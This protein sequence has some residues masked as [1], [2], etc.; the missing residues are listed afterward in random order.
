MNQGKLKQ[1][2]P[3]LSEEDLNLMARCTPTEKL[4]PPEEIPEF[5]WIPEGQFIMGDIFHN[6][7]N[8]GEGQNDERPLRNLNLHGF[9]IAEN[10]VTNHEYLKFLENADPDQTAD[11]LEEIKGVPEDAPVHS[12]TWDDADAYCKWREAQTPG[13]CVSLPTEAQWEKASSWHLI[14]ADFEVGRKYEFATGTDVNYEHTAFNRVTTF[15]REISKLSKGVNGLKG[16]SGNVWEWCRDYYQYNFYEKFPAQTFND[17]E[18]KRR[19]L[20]GGSWANVKRRLRISN[21]LGSA[22]STLNDNFGFRLV[23]EPLK[24]GKTE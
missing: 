3:N 19:V 14:G 22:A 10:V 13:K 4:M 15:P 9:W 5:V 1:W 23:M 24:T 12:V 16:A 6:S 20:R 21:R 11:F 18:S 17:R 7:S 2:Y 8:K